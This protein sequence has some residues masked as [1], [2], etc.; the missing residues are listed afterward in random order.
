[1]HVADNKVETVFAPIQDKISN[2]WEYLGGTTDPWKHF[3]PGL[4]QYSDLKTVSA[5]HVYYLDLKSPAGL[6]LEGAAYTTPASLDFSAGWNSLVWT[7]PAAK[8]ILDALPGLT[9]GV[10]YDAVARFNNQTKQWE[11]FRDSGSDDFSQFEPGQVYFIHML[12]P[13]TATVSAPAYS[14]T[15]TKYIYHNNQRLAKQENGVKYFY[16]SDHLGSTAVVADGSGAEV[17]RYE[18]QPYGLPLTSGMSRERYK[19]TGKELDDSTGLYDYSAR[20]YDSSLGRFIS[21]DTAGVDHAD[22]QSLNRYSY[23]LNNPLRYV[24][25]SGNAPMSA[26]QLPLGY[27]IL[28]TPIYTPPAG[29]GQLTTPIWTPPDGAGILATPIYA[30][31]DNQGILATPDYTPADGAGNLATPDFQLPAGYGVLMSKGQDDE[32]QP[33][34]YRYVGPEE[35]KGAQNDKYVSNVDQYGKPKTVFYTPEEGLDSAS[36]AQNAYNLPKTPTHRIGLDTTKTTNIYGG[37]VVGRKGI[38]MTTKDRIPVVNI[39]KLEE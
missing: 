1:L 26:T 29:L 33:T 30:P 36:Q 5:G 16:L 37:N 39:K 25:P 2:V 35:A 9:F 13:K 21:P 34:G 23:C 14:V 10:D 12:I 7:Y 31:P 38:E 24:D 6:V 8:P 11:Y 17:G 27:G 28:G 18:Y 15:R 4:E 19:F 22:P 32:A 3:R 20:Q